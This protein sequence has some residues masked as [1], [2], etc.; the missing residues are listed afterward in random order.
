MGFIG[1]HKSILEANL[2]TQ[3]TPL[4]KALAENG[5]GDTETELWK[6]KLTGN[7]FTNRLLLFHVTSEMY[8][9]FCGEMYGILQLLNF[10]P[11]W[12]G[13]KFRRDM[14]NAE[15]RLTS[16]IICSEVLYYYFDALSYNRF[17]QLKQTLIQYNANC[18]HVGD[19]RDVMEAHPEIFELI[20]QYKVQ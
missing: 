15:Y 16:G 1:N 14:R 7:L 9:G 5:S 8:Y 19:C 18:F 10:I 12:I 11:R 4:H 17:P 3:T 6:I 2:T 20:M 13:E